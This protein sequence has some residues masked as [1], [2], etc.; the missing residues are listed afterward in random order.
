MTTRAQAPVGVFDSGLGGLSVLRA[1]RAELPAESLLYL[2]DSRHAPYGEK[3]PEF[4]AGR[5]LRVCEWLVGQG[6]K[7][8]VIAC[9]TATA[10][11]VHLLREQLAVP[12]IGVEPGLKPA[13]ATSRSRVVGVLA[14]ESTLRSDK[15][16]R[17]L[18][19]VSGDCRV[20]CQP[21]YGL[22]PLI[23]RGDTH[24]PAVL[25]LLRAYLLPMLEA[26]AD[27]LVLGCTHY[28][29][30]QDAI[31]EIAGDRLTLIDTGHAVARHLGRT[32]AAA[33]LQATG[34]A[35]SPRFLS[36]AD[37]LPLQAMVTALLGEAPMAQR[38]DIGDTAV[39][40]LASHQ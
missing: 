22:V 15:F 3:P 4:I 2:A 23:E 26:G 11:A 25:E 21:G 6:C 8:L 20:L 5:T 9:N 14:T 35:A 12:V 36:T 18:G 19:N 16:A 27:T 28:P 10:Q 33:H 17:L 24:S 1:I 37:V 34:A 39:P 13:V 7:A 40:P 32:L 30:L 29:F 31:R 38:I